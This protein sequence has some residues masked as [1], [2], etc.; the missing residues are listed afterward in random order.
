MERRSKAGNQEG[1]RVLLIATDLI[2]FFLSFFPTETGDSGGLRA[3]TP[4]TLPGWPR[5]IVTLPRLSRAPVPL[6]GAP[7]DPLPVCDP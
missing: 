5:P 7:P 4:L 3:V 2:F 1:L 6:W